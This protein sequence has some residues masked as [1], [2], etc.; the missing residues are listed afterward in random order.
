MDTMSIATISVGMKQQQSQQD[1][2]ISVLKMAMGS[3][4]STGDMLS[5]MAADTKAME[6]SVQPHL[7]AGIDISI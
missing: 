6:L 1:A 5:R 4:E 2:G 3:A 7:G